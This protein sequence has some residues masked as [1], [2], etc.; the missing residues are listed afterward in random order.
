MTWDIMV[1]K[2]M[3]LSIKFDLDPRSGFQETQVNG[4]TDGRTMVASTTTE[5]FLSKYKQ[6]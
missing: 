4:R 3:Y 1:D 5:A 2:Y 6:S